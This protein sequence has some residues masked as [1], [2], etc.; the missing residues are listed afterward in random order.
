M[1]PK[2][3]PDCHEWMDYYDSKWHCPDC[4]HKEPEH[5]STYGWRQ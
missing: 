3:C 1:K 2:R 4:Q 5:D